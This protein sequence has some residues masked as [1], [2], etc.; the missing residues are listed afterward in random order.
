MSALPEKS[1]VKK[2]ID[3]VRSLMHK[4]RKSPTNLSVNEKRQIKETF[5]EIQ[6]VLNQSNY[7]ATIKL[8]CP[9]CYREDSPEKFTEFQD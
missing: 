6:A 8:R 1:E 5:D 2:A 3:T 7:S 4:Y 9:K